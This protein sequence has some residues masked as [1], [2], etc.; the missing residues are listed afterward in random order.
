MLKRFT[1]DLCTCTDVEAIAHVA[2]PATFNPE[3]A[4]RDVV[5]PAINGTLSLLN[6]A[7][8]YGKNVKSVVVTS[9]IVT[10][11]NSE[12]EPGHIFTESDWSD[13]A[14][15]QVLKLKEQG[16]PIDGFL[17]YVASK[18]EAERAVW[19]F[20]DEK[21][22]SFTL[23]TILPSYVYGAILPPPKTLEAVKAASTAHYVIDFFDGTAQDPTFTKTPVSFVDVVDVARAHVKAVEL[24]EKANG[25]RYLLNA[26]P[27]DF[28]E[29][30]DVLRK[31]FPERQNVIV[32][33]QPGKYKNIPNEY[34][35][36]KVTRELGIQYNSF[37]NTV[38]NTVNSVKHLY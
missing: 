17:A 15:Q 20:R 23:S 22:P 9:S 27:Y 3:D 5:N 35:G 36:S 11:L 12:A 16:K 14:F 26:G 21:K 37:A 6:S 2:S 4:I 29:A 1:N 19:K 8:K 30:V 13:A 24:A 38:L 10:L 25:Q 28:Q 34:D 31:H 32:K 7:H 18:N 33:G